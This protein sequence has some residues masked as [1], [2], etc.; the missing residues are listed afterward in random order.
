MKSLRVVNFENEKVD[1][2]DA[3]VCKSLTL[4]FSNVLAPGIPTTFKLY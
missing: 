4:E 2:L 3:S 1:I